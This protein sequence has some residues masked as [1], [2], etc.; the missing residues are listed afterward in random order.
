MA[1]TFMYI[2]LSLKKQYNGLALTK[3]EYFLIEFKKINI[4]YKVLLISLC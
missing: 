1:N 3:N 4:F 2:S